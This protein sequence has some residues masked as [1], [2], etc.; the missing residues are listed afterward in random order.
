MAINSSGLKITSLD[1]GA[2]IVKKLRF[3]CRKTCIASIED[4]IYDYIFLIFA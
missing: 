1:V 4:R 2:D 3:P